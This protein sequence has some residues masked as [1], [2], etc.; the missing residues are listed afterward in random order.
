GV[1]KLPLTQTDRIRIFHNEIIGEREIYALW[2][3]RYTTAFI[4][5]LTVIVIYF[6]GNKIFGKYTGHFASL[7]LAVNYRHVLN[8]HI[9]LPDIYNAFFLALS[10]F[11]SFYLLNAERK[12]RRL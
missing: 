6:I 12:N 8:S 2:W 5:F 4:S 7:I 1:I 9:G 11:T 3:G 10:V